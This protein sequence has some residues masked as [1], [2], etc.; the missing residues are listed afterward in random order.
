MN[1]IQKW[2]FCPS[3]WVT[4]RN[5]ES[6]SV[7]SSNEANINERDEEWLNGESHCGRSE[8]WSRLD[9]ISWRR[10]RWG[11]QR[12][13]RCHI[14]GNVEAFV[15]TKAATSSSPLQQSNWTFLFP[16]WKTKPLRWWLKI[17][18]KWPIFKSN[19]I[20]KLND[21]VT[22]VL[23]L[24]LRNRRESRST[25]KIRRLRKAAYETPNSDNF[26]SSRTGYRHWH[27]Y[28]NRT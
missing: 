14:W 26:A 20:R 10:Y 1:Y 27:V 9:F 22:I 19:S 13:R 28:S 2:Y 4:S 5:R 6:R 21:K 16:N 12:R 8:R 25:L 3:A 17:T 11:H 15:F 7:W 24:L 18:Q 23:D